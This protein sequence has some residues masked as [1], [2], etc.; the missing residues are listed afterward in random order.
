MF[1]DYFK[2]KFLLIVEIRFVSSIII[3]GA[4]GLGQTRPI[5]GGLLPGPG[6]A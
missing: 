1:N 2:M 5:S 6:L 3:K 4:D